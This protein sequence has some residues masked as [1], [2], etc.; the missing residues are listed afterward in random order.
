[1]YVH[2]KE[3]ISIPIFVWSEPGS[4]EAGAIQQLENCAK[5]PFAFHHVVALPDCHSGYGI[6]IGGVLATSRVI[7]PNAVGRDIGCGLF[8]VKTNL[9]EISQDIIKLILSDIREVIPLGFEHHKE[10]QDE[11]FMPKILNHC[12]IVEQQ[13]NSALKQLGTCGGGNHFLE[14][15]KDQDGFIWFMIHSGSR[16][17]G[18]RVAEHYDKIAKNLNETWFSSIP[19]NYQLSFL[20]IE[21]QEAK[22]YMNEMNFCLDFALANRKL[23]AERI[24]EIFVN[25]CKCS[26]S[27]DIN[28][29]HNY[30]KWENHFNKNVI[31]HRKGATSAKK[32]EIGIIPGSMG[33]SS[34][35]TRGLGNPLSFESCSHGAGRKMSRTKAINNLNLEEEKKKLNELNIVHSIRGKEDLEEAPGAYKDIIVVMNQQKDL[36]EILMTLQPLAVIKG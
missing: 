26:F 18:S 31:I 30:A 24:K 17:L 19:S 20:P 3:D 35:I 15:Q 23:M 28:I 8:A 16:N 33:T 22:L 27:E 4:I 1:M 7:I 5:L 13:Y 9:Q 36:T 21:S 12:P 32:D 14:I 2:N 6:T 29:H 10:K 25:Y 34:Y 11:K